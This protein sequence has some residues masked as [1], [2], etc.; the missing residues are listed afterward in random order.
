[1]GESLSSDAVGLSLADI[2]STVLA[3]A[4]RAR[5]GLVITALDGSSVGPLYINEAAADIFGHPHEVL[6]R[7]NLLDLV[8]EDERK[9]AA[10]LVFRILAHEAVGSDLDTVVVQANG[11]RVPIRIAFVQVEHGGRILT[12]NILT[13]LTERR[14]AEEQLARADRLAAVGTLAAGVAHE[15]NNPLAFTTLNLEGLRRLVENDMPAGAARTKAVALLGEIQ[16]GTNRVAAIVRDLSTFC[17]EDEA[18]SAPVDIAR[19]VASAERLV[20]HEVRDRAR[21]SVEVPTLPAVNA[22]SLRL[23][24]V[25]VNLLLNAAQA[26]PSA[27]EHNRVTVSGGLLE[28]GSIFVDVEDNGPGMPPG[29][30]SRV[31]EPFFTTKPVGV[32]TGL[33][34]SICHGI[35]SRLGGELTAK[36]T[37]GHG[38]TFRVA[39][40]R[41]QQRSG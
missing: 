17:R 7:S 19:I 26:F 33:G 20:M 1:V 22:S 4:E 6:M 8:A 32:G 28:D 5:L 14:A 27:S 31:F 40:P 16:A 10:E 38:S 25:F 37:V 18:E 41:A 12:V 39:I 35:V 13:D 3:V 34:L 30:L 15:I 36:S 24:Q 21:V 2:G 11:R 9:R 29:I 23:E